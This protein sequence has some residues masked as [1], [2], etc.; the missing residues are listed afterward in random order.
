LQDQTEKSRKDNKAAYSGYKQP[1]MDRRICCDRTAPIPKHCSC[2]WE[3]SQ[4]SSCKECA[5]LADIS[6]D[7]T[8]IDQT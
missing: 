8:Y 2:E 4:S 7:R 6:G 5:K 3:P 1:L